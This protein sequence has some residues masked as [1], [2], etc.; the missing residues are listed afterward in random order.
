MKRKS[1]LYFSVFRDADED[2]NDGNH[3]PVD[4][5]T[6]ILFT[7]D[8]AGWQL[9]RRPVAIKFARYGNY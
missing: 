6:G 7:N 3:I 4:H 1:R 9:G 8:G 2:T 5:G